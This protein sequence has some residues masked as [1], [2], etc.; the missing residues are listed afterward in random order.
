MHAVQAY[1]G[2]RLLAYEDALFTCMGNVLRRIEPK[3]GETS[4][5]VQLPEPGAGQQQL[6]PS[7]PVV[8]GGCLFV[9]ACD[10]RVLRVDPDRGDV[11]A[12]YHVGGTLSSEPVIADGM[13]W[14]GTQSGYLVGVP[15]G[16]ARYTGWY[17]AG[18]N[19][20]HTSSPDQIAGA[21]RRSYQPAGRVVQ[22]VSEIQA[23]SRPV[24]LVV[25]GSTNTSGSHAAARR[26]GMNSLEE[27]G[28]V[29]S[30]ANTLDHP[31]VKRQL[32][33]YHVVEIATVEFWSLIRELGLTIPESVR[34]KQI[35][36]LVLAA[37]GHLADVVT[38]TEGSVLGRILARTVPGKTA[39]PAGHL[40][41]AGGAQADD[42][43]RAADLLRLAKNLMGKNPAA[44][45]RRL[46]A[47][48][49]AYPETQAAADA[50]ELLQGG[51]GQGK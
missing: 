31:L 1:N 40:P 19:A 17:Q 49:A 42:E 27:V 50:R 24:L 29:Q 41:F 36:F 35:H 10:G 47:L 26:Y 3:T 20:A 37:D 2:A 25:G 32:P 38:R 22:L 14:L 4:W 46:Q 13:I 30:A 6:M 28:L 11:L 15:T 18:G 16:D 44:A 51:A 48:L 5:A 43:R 9:A 33:S 39:T 21:D 12:S 7:P 8:A 23:Q 34:G 45:R